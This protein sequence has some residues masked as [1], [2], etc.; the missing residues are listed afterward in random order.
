M[1]WTMPKRRRAEAVL[2]VL[3][4]QDGGIYKRLDE[5]R[6]LLELLQREMPGVL[7]NHPIVERWLWRQDRF[8]LSLA[9]AA[10]ASATNDTPRPWPGHPAGSNIF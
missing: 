2:A 9:D 7:V 5:N 3:R 4:R 10:T 1:F 6:A 8:L